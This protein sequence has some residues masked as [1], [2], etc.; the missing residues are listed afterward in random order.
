M[1]IFTLQLP[2][3]DQILRG[4]TSQIPGP[5]MWWPQGVFYQI[6]PRSFQDSN[7]DGIGDLQ[8]ITNR[9][10]YLQSLGVDA[11]WIGPIYPSSMT[12]FGYD[13]T[14]Y[15][16]IDPIFGS[17]ADFD[18]LLEAAHGR[19]IRVVLD[20]IPNHTSDEHP[21]F[22]ESKNSRESSKR[23]WYIWRDAKTDGS[24]PNNWIS[25][26]GG[27]AWTW[28]EQTQQ[29]YLH[30]FQKKQPDL[31]WRDPAV[32]EAMHRVLH[33]WLKRG[34]DGFRMDAVTMLIKHVALPDM[35][36]VGNWTGIELLQKHIYVHNQP[37]LHSLLRDFRRICDSYDRDQVIL[38]E[39]GDLDP[40]KLVAYYGAEQDELHLPFNFTLMEKPWHAVAQ[41]QAITAY[42]TALP[43]GATPNFVFGNHDISR[44]A[45]RYGYANH[46]SVG[47]LLM[48]LQGVPTLYYGDELGMMDGVIPPEKV[49]DMVGLYFLDSDR[50]RDPARTP[51]QWDNGPNAG[52]TPPTADPWLPISDNHREINVATQ[53]SNP[54]STLKFYQTL[55]SLRRTLPALQNGSITFVDG[56]PTDVVAYLRQFNGQH[57][58]I[59]INFA[60]R[61]FTLDLSKL[62]R[63]AELLLSSEFSSMEPIR[64]ERMVIK[65]NESLLLR[66]DQTG[67]RELTH[68]AG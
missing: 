24:P 56:T 41:K 23:N 64:L 52:F 51:M 55:I 11:L 63:R 5:Q 58:L 65:A 67:R 66:L 4:Q 8:G 34:V 27:S 10:D 48:T 59:I 18:R 6:Y 21:W 33:F 30:L 3:P 57:L 38:G 16:N 54:N 46:R 2:A 25:F 42:Y 31:N 62:A 49:Q 17:L 28:D 15:C 20:F 47:M 19:N 26:F 22:I 40:L 45:T 13:V 60:D 44:L 68:N 61:D 36:L 1:T 39:T 43:P 32:V 12:D 9:L 50:G 53:Q 7:G 37:E 29:Y 35:P 14:D